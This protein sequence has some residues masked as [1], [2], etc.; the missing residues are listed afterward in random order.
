MYFLRLKSSEAR[1]VPRTVTELTLKSV[2][3]PLKTSKAITPRHVHTT[4]NYYKDPKD[5]TEH[6]PSIAGKR[7][8]FTQPS[9]DVEHVITDI[10]GRESDFTLD[11]HGFQLHDHASQEKSFEDDGRIKEVYYPEVEQ[12]VR[13]V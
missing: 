1:T 6:A 13:E 8:T 3:F 2:Q 10:T 7:S 5:G 9:I 11:S 4:I 12:L